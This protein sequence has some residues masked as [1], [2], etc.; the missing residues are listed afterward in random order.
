MFNEIL[1][2]SDYERKGSVYYF[3]KGSSLWYGHR[4]SSCSFIHNLKPPI[5][6]QLQLTDK[7]IAM[8]YSKKIF[9]PKGLFVKETKEIPEKRESKSKTFISLF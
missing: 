7:A 9:E 4:S 6:L 2:S 3:D 1:V 8:G 5:Y